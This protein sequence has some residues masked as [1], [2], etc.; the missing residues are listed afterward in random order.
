MFNGR[1][2]E[3]TD[4]DAVVGGVLRAFGKALLFVDSTVDRLFTG[5]EDLVDDVGRDRTSTVL[6]V[7][8]CKGGWVGVVLSRGTATVTVAPSPADSA[9]RG[10]QNTPSRREGA[11]RTRRVVT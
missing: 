4:V 8:G 3:P 11:A 6:G 7:D 10:V 9:R 5:L 1:V 2:S